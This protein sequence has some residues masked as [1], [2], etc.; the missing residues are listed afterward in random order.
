MLDKGLGRPRTG[1]MVAKGRDASYHKDKVPQDDEDEQHSPRK[2]RAHIHNAARFTLLRFDAWISGIAPGALR[3]WPLRIPG[4]PTLAVLYGLFSF[5][6]FSTYLSSTLIVQSHQSAPQVQEISTLDRLP[7]DHILSKISSLRPPPLLLDPD[8]LVTRT[9]NSG[10]S[11]C[12]WAT[13]AEVADV[14]AW[15][16]RWTGPISLLVVTTA[17]PRSPEHNALLVKLAQIH[18]DQPSLKNTLSVHVLHLDP[19]T[20]VHPNAFLNL[21]RLLS[22]SPGV[23]L[24]PGNLSYAPP[25]NLYKTLLSQQPTSSSALT[26]GRTRKRRPVI[27]TTKDHTSFPF[28]PLAPLVMARDEPTWCTERFFA[29]M[30]RAADWEECLWQVWLAN[31]GDVEVKLV[32]GWETVSH[33]GE[34][35]QMGRP[36][37][38]KLHRRLV[39]KFRSETCALA[40]RRFAALREASSSADTKKARWLKRVCRSWGSS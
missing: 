35:E 7:L 13:E 17:I 5:F 8:V 27:L 11:A 32:Q 28:A 12:V 40:V 3:S 14:V 39:S 2:F 29:G 20:D 34:E 16:S 36:A 18:H 25:K 22:S 4:I 30:S 23:V 19:A 10:I 33:N 37:A 24:F 1:S 9:G 21:A 38:A 15:S 26:P 6:V 31:F